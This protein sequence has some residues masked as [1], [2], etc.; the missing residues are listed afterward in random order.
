MPAL[1]NRP[2]ATAPSGS[3]GGAVSGTTAGANGQAGGPAASNGAA[4]TG[5][6]GTASGA[7]LPAGSDRPQVARVTKGSGV[8][9]N[10]HG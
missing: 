8:L 4:G 1:A 5:A 6:S 7:P 9:P 3:A 2:D 10:D